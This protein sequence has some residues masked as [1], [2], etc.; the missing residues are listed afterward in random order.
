M[1][2]VEWWMGFGE[3]PLLDDCW[4]EW[5]CCHFNDRMKITMANEVQW[6]T[7]DGRRGRWHTT[8]KLNLLSETPTTRTITDGGNNSRELHKAFIQF[9]SGTNSHYWHYIVIIIFLYEHGHRIYAG[10]NSFLYWSKPDDH[11]TKRE[12]AARVGFTKAKTDKNT[13]T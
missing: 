7:Y 12:H 5:C 11:I 13:E 4:L 1:L 6:Q 10:C 8:Y 9:N 2:Y 3:M